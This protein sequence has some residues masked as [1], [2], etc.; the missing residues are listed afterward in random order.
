MIPCRRKISVLPIISF[1]LLNVDVNTT[2]DLWQLNSATYTGDG[3]EQFDQVLR[4]LSTQKSLKR[5]KI[6]GPL[7]AD[8]RTK[9]QHGRLRERELLCATNRHLKKCQNG[10]GK[11]AAMHQRYSRKTTKMLNFNVLKT[12]TSIRW[13]HT[14]RCHINMLRM[15]T[16]NISRSVVQLWTNGK[17]H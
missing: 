8:V 10:G 3:Y 1:Y 4:R 11:A 2:A 13:H 5:S 17:S 7:V 9:I 15:A 12:V 16:E 6:A 14:H